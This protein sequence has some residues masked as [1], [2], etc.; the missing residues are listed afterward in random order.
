M[1]YFVECTLVN[2]KTT[3]IAGKIYKEF[4]S[5][6]DFTRWY[7]LTKSDHDTF[8]NIYLYNPIDKP[9]LKNLYDAKLLSLGRNLPV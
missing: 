6:T 1:I 2:L 7:E 8:T 9:K 4:S 3:K 5:H